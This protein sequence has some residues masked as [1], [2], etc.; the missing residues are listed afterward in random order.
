[1]RNLKKHLERIYRKV[2]LKLVQR[3]AQEGAHPQP[4]A[5]ST[6]SDGEQE[7][8]AEGGP[9]LTAA[10]KGEPLLTCKPLPWSLKSG[11]RLTNKAA[12]LFPNSASGGTCCEHGSSGGQDQ[13]LRLVSADHRSSSNEPP[14]L[15]VTCI[16]LSARSR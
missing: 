11:K 16:R 5:A 4:I 7:T 14:F 6:A 2:A 15:Q 13:C 3:E 8:A 10:V 9:Q 1:M 12:P